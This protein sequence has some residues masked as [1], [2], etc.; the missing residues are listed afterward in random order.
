M[1]YL[2]E[3]IRR[4]MMDL[5]AWSRCAFGNT[6]DR[7]NAKQRELEELKAAG[8][9][10]NLDRINEVRRE[11]NDLLH[12]EEVFWWQQSR[13]IWFPAGDKNTKFFHQRASQRCRKNTIK[14]LHDTNW[15]WH[16][17]TG[18]IATIAEAYYKE[19]FT[20]LTDLNMEGVLASMDSLDTEEMA[21]NLTLSYTEEEVRV[22]L[23]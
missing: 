5:V 2:F 22:A 12:H 13:S 20:A 17:N 11:I 19:L 15:I 9:G 14:G 7:L 16:T 6:W 10:E 4:C 18:E 3:K 1:F 8:F 21:R 23:F